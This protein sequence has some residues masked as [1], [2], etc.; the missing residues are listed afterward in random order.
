MKTISVILFCFCVSNLSAQQTDVSK[1]VFGN[2]KLQLGYFV[3]PACQFGKVAGS[4]AVL[5]GIGAGITINNKVSLS[6]NY[7]FIIT[8]NT[9]AGEMDQRLYL[10]QQYAG[11]RGEY[12]LFPERVTHINFRV[13]AGSGHTEFDLKDA[14]ETADVP[15]KDAS[16]AYLEPGIALEVNLW[17]YLKL[18][19]GAGYRIVSHVT[20][21]DMTEKDF[22][23][24]SC[25]AGFKLGI[26]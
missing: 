19:L 20:F 11:I 4:T 3:N 26:F 9:P 1:T 2:T 23:G 10:D 18:D 13:E 16:F 22:R 21:G 8:E 5:P 14:F 12:A 25:S 24:F 7:R 17:K 6:V 15:V